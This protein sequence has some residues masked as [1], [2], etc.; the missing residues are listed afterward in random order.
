MHTVKSALSPE[1]HKCRVISFAS[2]QP[3]FVQQKGLKPKLHLALSMGENK[4]L[5]SKDKTLLK[6]FAGYH[7]NWNRINF[8]F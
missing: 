8:T 4:T 2:L 6:L 3:L 5:N 1:V 7:Q